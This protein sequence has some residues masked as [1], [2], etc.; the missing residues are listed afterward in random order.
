MT[1]TA[2]SVSTSA[3][4]LVDGSPNRT[5]LTFTNN[6]SVTVFLGT[7]AV[8]SSSFIYALTAGEFVQWTSEDGDVAPQG[9]WYGVTVSS[10]ASVAVGEINK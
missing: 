7:S 8:S 10:T 2:V 9:K 3:T 6:G 4:Q 1:N 5:L